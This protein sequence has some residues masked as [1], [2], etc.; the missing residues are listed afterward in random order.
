MDGG[1]TEF[2]SPFAARERSRP[3]EILPL[4]VA[5]LSENN[6]AFHQLADNLKH[7]D[8]HNPLLYTLSGM[9]PFTSAKQAKEVSSTLMTTTDW[10]TIGELTAGFENVLPWLVDVVP[11][12]FMYRMVREYKF[13]ERDSF[14][15]GLA[16][17][18]A[19]YPVTR[20]L[21]DHSAE[22]EP[23]LREFFGTIAANT[24]EIISGAKHFIDVMMP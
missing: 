24:D 15:V 7:V 10:P 4:M 17:Y 14:I 11:A 2:R 3:K 21:M 19:S 8:D 23:K 16:T 18:F 12:A 1:T 13:T 6:E 22:I 5:A 20:Y 9:L